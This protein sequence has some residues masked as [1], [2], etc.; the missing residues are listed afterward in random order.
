M[1]ESV[2]TLDLVMAR[3]L[4]AAV[5]DQLELDAY[6]FDVEP[7]EQGWIVRVECPTS[8]G[9]ELVELSLSHD[10]LRRASGESRVL[11]QLR[12]DL[13]GRLTDCKRRS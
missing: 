6:L 3:E 1:T 11:E 8:S 12:K 5:L 10:E 7:G 13:S 9:W 2:R 4:L